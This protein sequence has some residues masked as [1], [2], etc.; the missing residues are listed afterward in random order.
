MPILYAM[1]GIAFSGKS[2]VARRLAEKLGAAVVS[3]DAINDER[4]FRAGDVID[5]KEWEKT[6]HI[7]LERM[8]IFMTQRVA[9]VLDD[10]LSHRFLRD[11]YRRHAAGHGYDFTIVHVD[12]PLDVIAA[13]RE[14]NTLAPA[15]SEISDAVFSDHVARFQHPA[16]DETVVHLRTPAEIDRW[17]E[18]LSNS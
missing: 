10:T 1:C 6:S 8:S 7:A 9:I 3:L 15:R 11:R 18:T 13:R 5:D 16:S 12:T 2:T 14:A 4:G 17:I